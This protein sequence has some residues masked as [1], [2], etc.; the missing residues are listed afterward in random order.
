MGFENIVP[1]FQ[2]LDVTYPRRIFKVDATPPA[3]V[4]LKVGDGS[5]S[6]KTLAY[7]RSYSLTTYM[8]KVQKEVTTPQQPIAAS[9]Y[10]GNPNY[11][12]GVLPGR[13]PAPVGGLPK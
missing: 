11:D 4:V 12:Q 1:A 5:S 2:S 6:A 3:N 10:Y 7:S 13:G 8:Q 9:D